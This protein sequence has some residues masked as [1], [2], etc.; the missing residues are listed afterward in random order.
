MHLPFWCF[1]VKQKPFHHDEVGQLATVPAT[2]MIAAWSRRH[3]EVGSS[4]SRAGVKA[5]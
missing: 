3:G 1:V 5:G 2:V 4:G